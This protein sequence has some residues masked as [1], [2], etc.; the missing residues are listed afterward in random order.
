MFGRFFNKKKKNT[1]TEEDVLPFLREIGH[2]CTPQGIVIGDVTYGIAPLDDRVAISMN[3]SEIIEVDKWKFMTMDSLIQET[4]QFY[5]ARDYVAA[6]HCGLQALKL[7]EERT[8]GE[9][10]WRP[11]YWGG[12]ICQAERNHDPAYSLF[13]KALQYDCPNKAEVTTEFARSISILGYREEAVEHL[14]KAL[15][16]D[17]KRANTW[18]VLAAV[19]WDSEKRGEAGEAYLK[20]VELE[21]A[22]VSVYED[23]GNLLKEL[24]Y[25]VLGDYFLSVWQKRTTDENT[26]NRTAEA[27]EIFK[28]EKEK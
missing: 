9:H 1:I 26:P 2:V 21:P 16:I 14:H 13:E 28:Q 19:Y 20:A 18:A 22:M 12:I 15:T 4:E 3:N 27:L 11:Y 25:A 7:D 23:V 24:G 8:E 6:R 5:R 10:D 17:D